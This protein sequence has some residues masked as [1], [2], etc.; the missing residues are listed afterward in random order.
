MYERTEQSVCFASGY[1]RPRTLPAAAHVAHV[2]TYD[3]SAAV[4]GAASRVNSTYASVGAKQ[5][6]KNL[7][8]FNKENRFQ[9]F[10]L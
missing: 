7:V 10:V 4:L 2:T 5:S 9:V 3:L 6:W 8:F 1:R